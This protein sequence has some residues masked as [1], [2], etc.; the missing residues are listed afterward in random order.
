MAL[1][2]YNIIYPLLSVV[3]DA[4]V[5][6]HLHT[7]MSMLVQLLLHI[8]K[9]DVHLVVRIALILLRVKRPSIKSSHLDLGVFV[10][11]SLAYVATFVTA[12][13]GVE[14]TVAIPKELA[15]HVVLLWRFFPCCALVGALMGLILVS[16]HPTVCIELEVLLVDMA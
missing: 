3:L 12:H 2:N 10:F 11:D 4:V 13:N 14:L 1:L 16:Y 7:L 9:G 15:R 5:H 6:G 8:V